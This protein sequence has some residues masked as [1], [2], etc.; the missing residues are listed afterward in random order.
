[1][2]KF[3]I[4]IASLLVG[5]L[6]GGGL[7]WALR[8]PVPEVQEL[9]VGG[10]SSVYVVAVHL[11]EKFEK[12]HPNIRVE[13]HSVGSGPG[14]MNTYKGVFDVGMSSRWLEDE[15]LEW[16]LHH[17]VICHDAIAPIVHPDNPVTNLT[18]DQLTKIFLGEIRNWKE[19]GGKDKEITV[20]IRE[21]G[22]GTRDAWEEILHEDIYPYYTLVKVGT[23]GVRAAVAG[24]PSAI[25]YITIA[26][27]DETVRALKVDGVPP[28]AEAV[29]AEDYGIS[30]P[31]LF[32][33]K[34]EP[35]PLERKLID[36]VLGPEGQ[37]FLADEGLVPVK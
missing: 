17:S 26:A 28:V 12:K 27:V 34:G 36:F 8:P 18:K 13:M 4:V 11:A 7:V 31:F 16:G 5:A 20:I 24:D 37:Q 32:L 29:L 3:I 33:T 23:G 30:R 21:Y 2:P 10:S 1:M 9:T 22:S 6:V 14:I 25:G 35:D 15:E 19:V